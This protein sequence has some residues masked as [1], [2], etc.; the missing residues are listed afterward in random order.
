MMRLPS[1]PVPEIPVAPVLREL[2][3]EE[4][5]ESQPGERWKKISCPFHEDRNP[6]ASINYLGF[7]CFSCEREGDAYKLI[8][9]ET[10]CDFVAALTRAK[11]ITG[12]EGGNVRRKRRRSST[13]L[14]YSGNL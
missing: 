9:T 12:I 6:S 1:E 13:L 3:G 8:M 10:G 14:G 4:V 2:T 11:E 5:Y 7:H